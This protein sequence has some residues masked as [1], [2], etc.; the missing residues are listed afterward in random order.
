MKTVVIFG[1]TGSIGQNTIKVIK[2]LPGYKIIGIATFSNFRVLHKQY[3][4]LSPEMIGIVD[5]QAY[6]EY[7]GKAPSRML[8]K[9]ES[10]L[11]KIIAFLRPDVLVC[12]FASAIGIKALMLA[13]KQKSRICLATK[14]LLVSYGQIIIK[15]VKKYKA[16]L[17]P[18]DSEHSALYQ[19]LE[20]RN[21]NDVRNLILTASG[22]PFFKQSPKKITKK[23][24]LNHPIWRMGNKITVDSATMMNKG[25]EVIEAHHLFGLPADQIKVVVHPEAIVHSMVEFKDGSILA[26]L[27]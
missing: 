11:A 14:E 27:S 17:L 23:H 7:S 5:D 18:I 1:S 9:G 3:R 6:L 8:V 25:L 22:G 24:V 16:E 13:I 19:C 26:Q 12:S 10:G 20:G 2:T 4:D 15:A 21:K